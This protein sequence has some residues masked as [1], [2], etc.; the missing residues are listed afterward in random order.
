MKLSRKKVL[1][2]VFSGILSVNFALCNLTAD[3]K[4]QDE[5]GTG[6][7][8]IPGTERTMVDE[9]SLN[10]SF[11][12]VTGFA[13]G[14][15]NDRS[16]FQEGDEQ[17]A[18]VTNEMEFFE[19]VQRAKYGEVKV[20]ELRADLNLGWNELSDEVKELYSGKYGFIEPYE[21]STS[22]TKKPVG[23]P[24]LIETGI[25]VVTIN[26]IDGLTIFSTTGN[27]IRHAEIKF[28]SDVNDLI[29][30]NLSFGG[31][32]EWDDKTV[33]GFAST[34][35]SGNRKRTGWTNIKLN[36]CKNVWIDHCSFDNAFDGNVDV[37]N[38]SSGIT[39]SWCDV[40]DSD[41]GRGGTNYK[42]AMYLEQLYQQNKQDA[43]VQ[44]FGIYKIMRDNGLTPE[45][46]M[47]YMSQHDKCH[48]CGAGD[49]DSWLTKNDPDAAPNYDKM[50]ANERVRLT[51]AY[52]K[53]S[54]IGQRL[55][56]VRCGIGH[57]YNCYVDDWD[58]AEIN[59][60]LNSD[61]KGTG[62]TISRQIKDAGYECVTLTRALDARDGASVAADTCVYY[63]TQGPI[64]GT[65]YH[66][67][68]G[69][70][71]D[72]YQN[73]WKYNYAL[74]VNS[75]VQKYGSE[76]VY[77]GSSWDNNGNNPFIESQ[78]YWD[79]TVKGDRKAAQAI[80]GN[81]KWRQENNAVSGESLTTLPYAY[82]TFP[83]EDV[84]ENIETYSGF[85]K[86]K[87]SAEDWLKTEYDRE[88]KMALEDTDE[89]PLT[90]LEITKKEALIFKEEG[91]M[92]LLVKALPYNTTQ[93]ENTYKWESSNPDVAAVN[94]CGQVMPVSR[95]AARITVTAPNGL[96]SYCD[97]TVEQLPASVEITNLPK[98]V[99]KGDIIQLQADVTPGELIDESVIWS[100][101]NLKLDLTA[102]GLLHANITGNAPITATARLMGNRIGA[103]ETK[104]RVT[105]KIQEP[106][107]YVSGVAVE[108]EKSVEA[109]KTAQ[110]HAQVLP[111]NATN[112]NVVWQVSDSAIALVD[113]TGLVTG[114]TAGATTVTV[115]TIN[116][117]FKAQ[118]KIVVTTGGA[119]T[120]D[121]FMVGDMNDDKKITLA[122]AQL[123]LKI[124]L[125]L[126]SATEK[127][128]KA[129]DIDGNGS[130]E[131]KD[132]QK[133]LRVALNLDTFDSFKKQKR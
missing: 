97:V 58:L 16:E 121:E 4:A 82:Q 109:G 41:M 40:G 55:P 29:I 23:N 61:P 120:G 64:T 3:V 8:E 65:A 133:I 42:T 115:T 104:K 122:D 118:C 76:E 116:G 31:M 43:S 96:S 62:K 119:V 33:S 63:G 107:V 69:N 45:Q 17:Y 20:I 81:W 37:E 34:G 74:I 86:V 38:G 105:I 113:Q 5:A 32:W 114:V 94:D 15:V 127:Q 111:E 53:Y 10:G 77:T 72:G 84:K 1:A 35:G 73:I 44:S 6:V 11:F 129:G 106:D 19:A 59:A 85:R 47:K 130:I 39:L 22:N 18:V 79:E 70:I 57:L 26:Q 50:D 78:S 93:D 125:N 90:S 60:L 92:Q 2:A 46:I 110:L 71:S 112:K 128:K 89:I 68:G 13:R 25:S 108:A 27:K 101:T 48:L 132:A 99:Y 102:E 49:K 83:L 123:A 56:M 126:M 95:G 51:L 75:S 103:Q 124:A 7:T 100:T 80:I 52:N 30:R 91:M 88:Y 87:M 131:L 66:P 9:D 14:R 21:Q 98:T 67:N 117:G 36:G 24:I 54:D 28:N 12:S